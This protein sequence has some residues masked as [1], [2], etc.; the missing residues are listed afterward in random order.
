MT[1]CPK[2]G[3]Q[4]P[5]PITKDEL[6]IYCP[7]CKHVW[8]KGKEAESLKESGSMEFNGVMQAKQML[9]IISK[10]NSISHELKSAFLAQLTSAFF[11][12]WFEGFKAGL[13]AD[14]V[15]QKD[16][17]DHQ[18]ETQDDGK[19]RSQLTATNPEHPEGTKPTGV[20]QSKDRELDGIPKDRRTSDVPSR[21][22]ESVAGITLIRPNYLKISEEKYAEIASRLIRVPDVYEAEFDGTYLTLKLKT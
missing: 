20:G 7:K 18:K 6:K 13:I 4:H 10:D 9:A 16:T 19:N 15:H 11:E 2:C 1:N 21:V 14:I 5:Q 8:Q 3:F 12:Q 17:V 22:K